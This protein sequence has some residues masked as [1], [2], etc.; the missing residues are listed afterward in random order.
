MERN[1][2]RCLSPLD[3]RYYVGERELGEALSDYL[4]EEAMVR[5]ELEVEAALALELAQEGIC[6]Q[7]QGEAIVAACRKVTPEEVYRE[8][9]RTQHHTRA[10]VNCIREHTPEEARPF[11]HLTATSFDI[12]DTANALRYRRATGEV[13]LPILLDLERTLLQLARRYKDT[14]QIGR[15]HGQWAV[16]ITFGYAMAGYVD[17]LGRRIEVVKATASN[18]RGKMAGAVG[19][20]NAASLFLADPQGFERRVL[21]RLGLEP[22]PHATQIVEPE[23]IT[24]F[25]HAL[26]STFGVLANLA[27][28][29]RHL[30]RSEID[31]VAEFFAQ[32]QV[33]SSTMPHKRNPWNFE[34]VKS[35]WKAF[36]PRM[37]TVYQDQI[38]EHQRDLT[39]SASARFIP[40]MIAGLALSAQRLLTVLPR[41]VINPE[42]M[43]TNLE[44][45]KTFYVAE[46]LYILLAFHGHPDA[47]EQV[48]RLTMMAREE[49][50]SVLELAEEDPGLRPYLARLTPEQK[51]VLHQP[52]TYL[53][54][55]VQKTEELCREWEERLTGLAEKA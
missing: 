19:G 12:V 26:T 55:V 15:T 35:M 48:R 1:I 28:D 41:L 38:S 23:F 49:G 3:H 31:E 51:K 13:L 36:M 45:A 34:H 16:P 33:G 47:H 18:L 30:Q 6:T 8:E 22:S 11:V 43:A 5:Y 37:I 32:D 39:N 44:K 10:L 42:A 7:T 2:Y 27:D 25:L 40:E 52:E 54:R 53:G 50:R 17:R 21:A 46:P 29:L 14:V 24:D 4:S 9:E 20:Y